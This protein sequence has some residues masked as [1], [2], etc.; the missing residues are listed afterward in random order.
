MPH[1]QAQC[2]FQAFNFESLAIPNSI[3]I[4]KRKAQHSIAENTYLLK[5]YYTTQGHQA[6][7]T[8]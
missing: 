8:K 7:C 5:Y 1:V 4:L 3:R 2:A 6:K